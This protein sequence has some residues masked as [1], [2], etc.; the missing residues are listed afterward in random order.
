LISRI[1]FDCFFSD[2][3][4]TPRELASHVTGR[5]R[6][7]KAR[8]WEWEHEDGMEAVPWGRGNGRILFSSFS[9]AAADGGGDGRRE[10]KGGGGARLKGSNP[11]WGGGL[12]VG[13][14][15]GFSWA[16]LGFW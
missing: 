3:C 4:G 8:R 12:V 11:S 15:I 5:T 13:A 2:A 7:R 14:G 16:F 1:G 6:K 9:A 10:M